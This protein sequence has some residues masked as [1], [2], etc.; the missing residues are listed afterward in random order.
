MWV[1]VW[2]CMRLYCV[3]VYG[4]IFFFSIFLGCYGC[5]DIVFC[6]F[7]TFFVCL[8]CCL[9][10]LVRLQVSQESFF[11]YI[12]TVPHD[13]GRVQQ[14]HP[15]RTKQRGTHIPCCC[16]PD[17][18]CRILLF[19]GHFSFTLICFIGH[20]HAAHCG[21]VITLVL[22]T[23]CTQLMQMYSSTLVEPQNKRGSSTWHQRA[24]IGVLE[25]HCGLFWGVYVFLLP[26]W[27]VYSTNIKSERKGQF[28]DRRIV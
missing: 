2:M 27:S 25:R 20:L 5:L 10:L 7:A 11:K 24:F 16:L 15:D 26:P 12:D 9:W 21:H 14:S 8:F 18:K 22:V 6:L 23:L 28:T 1:Y 17:G 19:N 13:P 3:C 4:C